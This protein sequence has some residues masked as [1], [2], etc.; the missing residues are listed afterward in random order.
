MTMTPAAAGSISPEAREFVETWEKV[1]IDQY[2]IIHLDARGDER[3]EVVVQ[4]GRRFM[5]TTAERIITQDR[6]LLTKDD[7]FLNGAFRPI[8]VPESVTIETNP[9]ALSDGEIAKLLGAS[10]IAWEEWLKTIDSPATLRRMQDLAEDA[11]ISL[12]RYKMIEA[13]LN[14]VAPAMRVTT[15]DGR[16]RQ[17]LDE[18]QRRET[19][20]KPD[21]SMGGRSTDYR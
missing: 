16:L 8:T 19:G 11:E 7:P 1:A 5:L 17:F 9:N 10:D 13:R 12:R 14:E 2:T 20:E 6:I 15:R 4:P 21:R 3:H 18:G